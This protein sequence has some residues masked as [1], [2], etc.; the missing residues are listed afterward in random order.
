MEKTG[1]KKKV[2]T[3]PDLRTEVMTQSTWACQ[4][5][6]E[7]HTGVI[8]GSDLFTNPLFGPPVGDCT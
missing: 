3:P 4:A 7:S 6:C 2:Y 5:Y 8:S 1:E